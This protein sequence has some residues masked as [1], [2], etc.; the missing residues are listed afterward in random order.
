V[1]SQV[2]HAADLG[3]GNAPV[4]RPL[5]RL[6]RVPLGRPVAPPENPRAL[7]TLHEEV[8]RIG[9]VEPEGCVPREELLRLDHGQPRGGQRGHA[10][11][12]LRVRLDDPGPRLRLPP[13]A[14]GPE[15]APRHVLESLARAGVGRNGERRPEID[16]GPGV[17]FLTF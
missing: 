12:C 14:E 9:V 10:V 15:A 7:G 13:C 5:L 3:V 8:P 1:A 11:F 2:S 6:D 4:E 17:V 16:K